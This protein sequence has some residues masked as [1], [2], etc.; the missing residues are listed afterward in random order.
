[1]KNLKNLNDYILEKLHINKDSKYINQSPYNVIKNTFDMELKRKFQSIEKEDVI[2]NEMDVITANGIQD[3]ITIK[4]KKDNL[5]IGV[6]YTTS[7][8]KEI[9]SDIEDTF[10]TLGYDKQ[11]EYESH[12]VH[13]N[14][15]FV[16]TFISK[17]K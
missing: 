6:S 8:I 17:P 1:M 13:N 4:I 12:I 2:F 7:L 9:I 11:Y 10:K 3:E 16:I 5:P 15:Y 14:K